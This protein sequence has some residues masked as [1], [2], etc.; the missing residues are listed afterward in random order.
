MPEMGMLEK[1]LPQAP[2]LVVAVLLA[3]MFL[4]YMRTREQTFNDVMKEI[5]N[6]NIEARSKTRQALDACTRAMSENSVVCAQQTRMIEK[7]LDRLGG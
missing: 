7:L 1:L 5:H 3:W 2:G 6:E 4:Q